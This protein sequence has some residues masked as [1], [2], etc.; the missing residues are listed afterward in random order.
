VLVKQ[1]IGAKVGQIFT[2]SAISWCSSA[3]SFAIF[4][5]LDF[6]FVASWIHPFASCQDF[7]KIWD[8]SMCSEGK[9]SCE[10]QMN[11]QNA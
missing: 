2:S 11:P 7:I 10:I 9:T 6:S 3:S 8:T 4:T 1:R 5:L